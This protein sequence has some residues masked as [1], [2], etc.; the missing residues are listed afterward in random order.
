MIPG[1][2]TKLREWRVNLNNTYG[3]CCNTMDLWEADNAA[4]ALTPHATSPAHTSAPGY[5]AVVGPRITTVF[6]MKTAVA[7]TP[8]AREATTGPT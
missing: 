5:S 6:V 2:R 4:T 8:T 7:T 1:V 3:S